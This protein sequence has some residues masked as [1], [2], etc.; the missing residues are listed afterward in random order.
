MQVWADSSP[1]IIIWALESIVGCRDWWIKSWDMDPIQFVNSSSVGS[2]LFGAFLEI[3]LVEMKDK[4]KTVKKLTAI[5]WNPH[6]FAHPE[7]AWIDET[8]VTVSLNTSSASKKQKCW[9]DVS[10]TL[11]SLSIR[12]HLQHYVFVEGIY[13]WCQH[14]EDI[15]KCVCIGAGKIDL[16]SNFRKSHQSTKQR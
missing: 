11:I 2:K 15:C 10:M 14:A 13:H 7:R 9:A 1:N 4:R 12:G 3:I 6:Q 5:P 16:T 8:Q